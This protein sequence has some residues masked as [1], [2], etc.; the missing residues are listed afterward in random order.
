LHELS[1]EASLLLVLDDLQWADQS[2]LDLLVH[3][4]RR[5]E[6]AA[7]SIAGAFRSGE[8]EANHSLKQ[9][10]PR[11]N[12]LRRLERVDLRPLSESESG[13]LASAL[14][15]GR[16]DQALQRELFSQTEGN[17]FFI[18]E[19][20]RRWRGSASISGA[21]GEWRL[22]HRPETAPTVIDAIRMRL[23]DLDDATR[24]LLRT[25][26]IAGRELRT[27]MIALAAGLEEEEVESR[28]EPA[29]ALGLVASNGH[30]G[31]R[32][33]HDKIRECLY[34]EI[35][36]TR[37]R[38][39]HG[40]IGHALELQG[41]ADSSALAYHYTRS[42][43]RAKGAEFAI[44]A[45]RQSIASFSFDSAIELGETA[46]TLLNPDDARQG[47][48][49]VEI[50]G[51]LSLASR[52]VEAAEHLALAASALMQANKPIDAARALHGRG[53][54]LW[55]LEAIAPAR[56]AFT[57]ALELL[58][59]ARTRE[60]VAVLID[61][62]SLISTS[63]L[64]QAAGLAL[65]RRALDEAIALADLELEASASR[66]LGNSL[67]RLNRIE[68][69]L[70][71][72]Q[73]ALEI[74]D[75]RGWLIEAC[76]TCACLL[77]ANYWKGDAGELKSYALRQIEYAERSHDLYQL[78]H[79]YSWLAGY[80]CASGDQAQAE[81][82]IDRQQEVVDR[83]DAPD[84]RAYLDSVRGMLLV[85]RGDYEQ[86]EP[87]LRRAFDLY[88]E[89]NPSALSWNVGLHAF[90]L[91]Q[92]GRRDEALAIRDELERVLDATATDSLLIPEVISNLAPI[93]IALDEATRV[94]RYRTLLEPFSGRLANHLVDRVLGRIST[95]ERDYGLAERRLTSAL[96]HA[97]KTGFTLE[98]GLT[99]QALAALG[100]ARN[101]GRV[102]PA[103]AEYARQAI[104]IFESAGTPLLAA[105]ARSLIAAQPAVKP[106]LPAGLSEREAE[107]VRLLA[108]G[109]SNQEIADELFISVKTVA[110]H[111]T[112]IF[113]K[114]GTVNRVGA[115]A[116]A[117][118]HG[119]V[120]GT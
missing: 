22:I 89:I 11:L 32:F 106:V 8:V 65:I 20:L 54:A 68:E 72:L 56:E 104:A 108:R 95:Y 63:E 76:E 82:M 31:Y 1:T 114:T 117:I 99:L 85:W 59:E 96:Q 16:I 103:A 47:E 49:R 113:A 34:L 66:T 9:T 69:A 42:G 4:A 74:A 38:R 27:S 26:S 97:T 107:V 118:N 61:Y 60:R 75:E 7:V 13:A 93:A 44:E 102:T 83:L 24:D 40:F 120:A 73:R 10:L 35:T 45:M 112:S 17:P 100:I 71:L 46:L 90:A 23:L 52:N 94:A 62:A 55:R 18:E 28:L 14:L 77:I 15:G 19:S 110:N 88:R 30:D 33:T 51:A 87:I 12:R 37:R 70:P 116:F 36:P 29:V 115:A 25:A 50:A 91:F 39:L 53:N 84:P 67:V 79:V 43:D 2:T 111:L 41:S 81:A 105:Q 98:K 78:R 48:V 64:E 109:A 86:A 6:G 80:H 101:A 3:V 5:S 57:S 92:L 119:L 21:N 58:G